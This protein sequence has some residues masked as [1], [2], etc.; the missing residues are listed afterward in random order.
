MKANAVIL[1]GGRGER[2]WPMSY[3]QRPKPL[4]PLGGGERSLLRAT[5]ERV[6]PLVGAEGKVYLVTDAA[7]AARMRAELDLP[8]EQL[9]V[10]PE[11]RNTAPAIGLAAAYLSLQDPQ[12]VMM[13]F[14]A[15]HL[16][17]KEEAFRGVV[18]SA[19][20]AAVS[21]HLV[22]LGVRPTFPAIGY[23]YIQRGDL[24][25][26]AEGHQVY[27]VARFAEKPDRETARRY[28]SCG[29]YSWNAGVFVWQVERILEE[30][31]R[32]LPDLAKCLA[33]LGLEDFAETNRPRLAHRW[34][35]LPSVS[36]DYGIMEKASDVAVVLADVG[37]SDLG[38]WHAVWE[39]M[40]EGRSE[41]AAWG[42]HVGQDTTRCLVWTSP[43]KVVA[44]LG[45]HDAVVVDTPEALLVSDIERAEEIRALA[46]AARPCPR[47]WDE[48]RGHD[49]AGLLSVVEAFPS[50]CRDALARGAAVSPPRS[51][52]G[53]SRV[54]C[55]GMGGSGITGDLLARLLTAEVTPHR[56][57]DCPEH[58]DENT[59]LVGFSYS[60]NT[61]ETLSA[62]RKGLDRTKRA[63][64]ISSG[65]E[66]ARLCRERA[67]PLIDVPSGMQPRAA[68]GYL[69]FSPVP[70][71]AGW[72]VLKYDPTS[73]MDLLESM[74]A[75]LRPANEGNAAQSL[76]DLLHGRVPLVYAGNALTSVAAFRWKTQMNENAKQPAFWAEL[77]ELCHNE[78]VGYELTNAV[79][80]SACV[81]FLRSSFDHPRVGARVEI[82]KEVLEKRGLRYA[83]VWAQGVEPVEQLLS[84]VYMG[85]WTSVYLALAN[86][87]DP[88]SVRPI[89]ELKQRLR[90]WPDS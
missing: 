1:A 33:E 58:V 55:V 25:M 38:D 50:Q 45:L 86:R 22:T 74:A 13:V 18:R 23:G 8:P 47:N 59:L 32:H 62:F 5:F 2:L 29:E 68:L 56:G 69:L 60:G 14:P 26:E 51:L 30:F 73:A 82:L 85:D 40:R 78:I 12:S 53:F 31:G 88:S 83:E 57:Y 42:R 16:V 10:E 28:V 4:L 27:Q 37:W 7:L 19:I 67:V 64:A 63:M 6:A 80:P 34:S 9:I 54:A 66:L 35:E 46:R 41:V 70:W 3:P 24:I 17:A 79:L 61:E 71:F 15:D 43:G 72:G 81:V 75:E 52:E 20:K 87:V 84:L 89:E 21:G 11:G 48:L 76:A 36:V 90:R 44:T 65:G 77:P 49:S 39:A